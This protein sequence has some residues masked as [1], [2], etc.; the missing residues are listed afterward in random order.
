MPAG[1]A[2]GAG[3]GGVA[4]VAVPEHMAAALGPPPPPSPPPPP[5]AASSETSAMQQ[6]FNALLIESIVAGMGISSLPA[7][8]RRTYVTYAGC[9]ARGL[10]RLAHGTRLQ[11]ASDKRQTD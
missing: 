9:K 10:L 4:N 11:P 3:A 2:P 5:H 7:A 8:Y 6:T 1:G